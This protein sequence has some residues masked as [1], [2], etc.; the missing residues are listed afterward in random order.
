MAFMFRIGSCILLVAI[1]CSLTVNCLFAQPDRL[2]LREKIRDDRDL[3]KG[4]LSN[5][6][7]YYLKH[8]ERAEKR[9]SIHFIV[10]VGEEQETDRQVEVAHLLEHLAFNS[11]ANFP[12]VRFFFD[13]NGLLLGR[14][15]NASTGA[16]TT[17]YRFSVP[18]G[19]GDLL[20]SCLGLIRD[21]ADFKINLDSAKVSAEKGAVLQEI[22][23]QDGVFARKNIKFYAKIIGVN[24]H[25]GRISADSRNSLANLDYSEVS[26]F[27]TNWYVPRHEALV[28]AGNFNVDS[29]E[30]E[31]KSLFGNLAVKD[32]GIKIRQEYVNSRK[33][34]GDK[35]IYFIKE[36]EGGDIECKMVFKSKYVPT[37]TYGDLRT[38][39]LRML[40]ADLIES[41][42]R[43]SAKAQTNPG[44]G[45]DYLNEA[46]EYG[47]VFSSTIL[48]FTSDSSQV[49]EVYLTTVKELIRIKRF[50]FSMSE[51]ENAKDKIEKMVVGYYANDNMN[52]SAYERNFIRSEVIPSYKEIRSDVGKILDGI[53]GNDIA[54]IMSG[55]DQF[56]N[57]D[58]VFFVPSRYPSDFI[59]RDIVREWNQRARKSS[60]EPFNFVSNIF[61][62][63]DVIQQMKTYPPLMTDEEV[64]S[65]GIEFS[66][67]IIDSVTSE[68]VVTV[69]LQ[70]GV[71]VV[72]KSGPFDSDD[73]YVHC[74]KRGNAFVGNRVDSI[75]T[76]YCSYLVFNSGFGRLTPNDWLEFQSVRQLKMTSD[77]TPDGVTVVGQSK[78]TGMD[79]L[80]QAIRLL[81]VSPVIDSAFFETWKDTKRNEINNRANLSDPTSIYMDALRREFDFSKNLLSEAAYVDSLDIKSA[82]S[83]YKDIYSNDGK[84]NLFIVGNFNMDT[85]LSL[86]RKY[87][88]TIP[89]VPVKSGIWSDRPGDGMKSAK[90]KTFEGKGLATSRVDILFPSTTPLAPYSDVLVKVLK[91][92]FG[93]LI[94][95]RLRAKEGVSYSPRVNVVKRWNN[96]YFLYVYFDCASNRTADAVRFVKEE[97][98]NLKDRDTQNRLLDSSKKA[99]ISEINDK[100]ADPAFWIEWLSGCF[101]NGLDIHQ[102]NTGKLDSEITHHSII[103]AANSFSS[104]SSIIFIMQATGS[105]VN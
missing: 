104:D 24:N 3:R 25:T 90:L 7:T 49:E 47:K 56:R 45:V 26:R 62:S 79:D 13:S 77:I 51:I 57:T 33:L 100:Q 70:N 103:K 42:C 11:T 16:K 22:A 40:V 48:N 55:W 43:A 28:I 98:A 88:G 96:H 6:F 99:V 81:M 58:V 73:M 15:C 2:D 12:D 87:I 14:E 102:V 86:V 31:V 91:D 94:V 54:K 92:E 82:F 1:L 78:K 65:L 71:R 27:Y 85:V 89:V 105:S 97:F 74:V 101:L 67:N 75:L 36:N 17:K 39:L 29:V 10:K 72:L 37:I 41:R 4:V 30:Q 9:V 34:T 69:V 52:V 84:Y 19:N 95:S 32:N 59:N 20:L 63:N 38:N 76:K 18:E 83:R 8:E 93:R 53:G 64:T 5:G 80:L 23:R 61:V 46:S 66:E 50:G 60:I 21:W 35:G 68:N 44:Y